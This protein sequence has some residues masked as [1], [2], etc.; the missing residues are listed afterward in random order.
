MTYH[1]KFGRH[2]VLFR[3]IH[4][5]LFFCCMKFAPCNWNS[6]CEN[7]AHFR[8]CQQCDARH[9]AAS[10][11]SSRVTTAQP[12][13]G[14]TRPFSLH[15]R[16]QRHHHLHDHTHSPLQHSPTRRSLICIVKDSCNKSWVPSPSQSYSTAL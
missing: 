6:R 7:L 14:E 10:D 11:Q 1:L 13:R 16:S 4:G 9:C 3:G 2:N 12:E 8:C 15:A 5:S